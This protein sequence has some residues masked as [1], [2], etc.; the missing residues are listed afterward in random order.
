MEHSNMRKTDKSF[1]YFMFITIVPALA[2]VFMFSYAY[3]F[4]KEDVRF[5]S[6]E[7]KGLALIGEIQKA[8]FEIQKLRGLSGIKN[9]NQTHTDEIEEKISNINISLNHAKN[10]LEKTRF[11]YTFSEDLYKFLQNFL[12]TNLKNR[13]FEYFSTAIKEMMD[14]IIQISHESNLILNSDIKAYL[15]IENLTYLFPMLIEHNGQIRAIASS[16]EKNKDFSQKQKQHITIQ[17]SK[18][19]QIKQKLVY[20]YAFLLKNPAKPQVQNLFRQ[21]ER[22]Q[23][24]ILSFSHGLLENNID[25]M[26]A[27]QIFNL[28]TENINLIISLYDESKNQ[29]SVEL[30]N[31][32]QK[33]KKL[34]FYIVLSATAS[35]FFI[36]Y[37]NRFFFK[38]NKEYITQIEEL[39]VKDGM[40]SLYNRR[41]FDIVFEKQSH[42]RQLF[43]FI[44]LDID[45]FKEYND[46]YGHQ[47]GDRALVVIAEVLK[48][49]LKRS[50]DTVFR[51]GGEEFGI[52]CVNL[53]GA[54]AYDFALFVKE[55]I[56][57]RKIPHIGS[58]ISP[59]LSVSMGIAVASADSYADIGLIY[60]VAD[61]ALYQ[62]KKEGR[63]RVVLHEV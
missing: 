54:Q 18:I 38:K 25:H 32:I 23:E 36:L 63:D 31:E 40:T 7:Q 49:S 30:E 35:V 34:L 28:F 62:A 3:M 57:K 11:S 15:L 2:I 14:Y 26:E 48:G 1:S 52:I 39:T 29:L 19:D 24:K 51:L 61:N 16:I 60:K 10:H 46:N 8:I 56:K 47:E 21:M 4:V 9:P 55:E 59:Y 43:A 42:S 6:E 17:I 12:N 33:L 5:I 45:F 44:M 53:D 22:A 50:T 20:N 37:L 13:D 27:T 58:S 41:Y